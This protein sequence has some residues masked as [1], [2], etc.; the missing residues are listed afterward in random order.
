MISEEQAH[1]KALRF[2]TQEPPDRQALDLHMFTQDIQSAVLIRSR[3]SENVSIKIAGDEEHCARA[4]H[5]CALVGED[6]HRPED[7]V[8]AAI[9]KVILYLAFDGQALFELV[10][11]SKGEIADISPFPSDGASFL[12]N[13]CVQIVPRGSWRE[14]E[15]KYAVLAGSNVWRVRMPPQLGGY[16]GYRRLLD[17]ISK[18]AS[19]GP[20][21][22][23]EDIREGKWPKDFIVGDYRR[24]YEVERYQ[25]TRRWGWN[26]RD[27]NSQY[28]TEYYQFYR[29]LTFRW[30]IEVLRLHVVKELNALLQRLGIAASITIVGLPSPEEILVARNRMEKGEID[31]AEASKMTAPGVGN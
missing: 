29:M 15:S 9:E 10:R 13:F 27:W 17:R 31:F 6:R 8:E 1:P 22:Q 14:V 30:S 7:T 12:L 26:C 23:Q 28:T 3:G 11:D 20:K 24:A 19:L 18:L 21:F 5:I 16:R 4:N 2:V 25:V